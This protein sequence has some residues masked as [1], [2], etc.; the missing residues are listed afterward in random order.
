MTPVDTS[1]TVKTSR[2]LAHAGIAK[3]KDT[4]SLILG[5]RVLECWKSHQTEFPLL[6][7]L[8]KAYLCI[9]GTSVPS[10]RVFSTAGDIVRSEHR[11][12]SPQHVDQLWFF[13]F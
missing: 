9:S 6:A 12:L 1:Q 8:A 7:N 11:V 4:A 10:E 2:E 5:G 3:Y 13:F